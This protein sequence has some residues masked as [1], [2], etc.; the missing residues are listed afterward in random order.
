MELSKWISLFIAA[1]YII[2]FV[3]L[4]LTGIEHEHASRQEAFERLFWIVGF[5]FLW[6]G[7]SLGCIWWS[8]ELAEGLIG[9]K[10]GLISSTSP[11][12]LVKIVGWIL[13]LL[14]AFIV[15]FIWNRGR[16]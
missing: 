16:V 1:L 4:F 3:C 8:D 7:V 6:L 5:M 9:A 11:G 12:W 2:A 14:P 15:F 13:L 10:C